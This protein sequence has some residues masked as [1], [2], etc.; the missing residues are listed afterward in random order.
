[1]TVN[2]SILFSKFVFQRLIFLILFGF[3]LLILFFSFGLLLV[4]GPFYVRHFFRQC[5]L[6]AFKFTHFVL[7]LILEL[8]HRPLHRPRDFR[9][10]GVF[11]DPDSIT[12]SPSEACHS[13]R[14]RSFCSVSISLGVSRLTLST[15]QHC[16]FATRETI[17]PSKSS[18]SSP[19]GTDFVGLNWSNILVI[20]TSAKSLHFPCPRGSQN[21]CLLESR[22][23]LSPWCIVSRDSPFFQYS[24]PHGSP[25]QNPFGLKCMGST[26]NSK[27]KVKQNWASEKAK[28]ENARRLRR[29]MIKSQNERV[30]W[31]Q[32]N[33]RDR[34]WK[35][36]YQE[37]MK[38]K[39][40]EKGFIFCNI[41]I[42]SQT[43]SHASSSEN[44]WSKSSSGEKWEKLEN[45]SAWNLAK[46]RNTSDVIDEA[47]KRTWK[48]ILRHWRISVISGMLN[49]RRNTRSINVELYFEVILQKTTQ[50]LMQCSQNNDHPHHTNDGRKNNG[51]HLQ[52]YLDA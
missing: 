14:P 19:S 36:L 39:L 47:R 24:Y 22:S 30:S 35:V 10:K 27:M 25:G 41:T 45:I 23:P 50:A 32:R 21:I 28:L 4:Q 2:S 1:M 29:M 5:F 11:I 38:T 44:T 6:H 51:Y 9:F 43:Y 40:Q 48:Y 12:P 34:V 15:T 49:L 3:L 52:D 37:F 42:W 46:V 8:L 17:H 26:R 33:P 18:S 7:H 13:K 20:S 16:A 31:K